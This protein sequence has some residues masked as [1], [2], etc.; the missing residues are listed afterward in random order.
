VSA[1]QITALVLAGRREGQVD[2]LAAAAGLADKCLIPIGGQ[3]MILHVVDA[4]AAVP[5]I[6]TILVSINDPA[7]L[8]ELAP[9]RALQDSGKLVVTTAR[10]NLVDSVVAAV[11][12]APFPVLV[13]TA[14]NALLTPAAVAQFIA[15]AGQADVAVAFARRQSV[16]AAH[17]E[18]QRRFYKFSDESYS[19]CNTYWLGSGSALEVAEVFRSGGQ[20]AKHPLRIVEAFGL[21]NLLRFHYGIGTLEAA[22]DRFSRRFGQTIKPV[23]LDDGAVAI[24][25]DNQRTLVITQEI[26]G[27]RAEADAAAAENRRKLCAAAA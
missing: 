8:D 6:G 24:D 18:G 3:P 10:A 20:F 7:T 21:L 2:P 12:A 25:V 9:V 14:D 4:L 16:F 26:F 15:A 23:I 5:Q 1:R 27:Q 19:N 22:F 17:P 11:E 13:T